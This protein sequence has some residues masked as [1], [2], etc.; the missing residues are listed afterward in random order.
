MLQPVGLSVTTSVF[1]ST[2]SSLPPQPSKLGPLS[3]ASEPRGLTT[4]LRAT[5]TLGGSM[6]LVRGKAASRR[7]ATPQPTCSQP[8][9][10]RREKSLSPAQAE[11]R[12]GGQHQRISP[13]VLCQTHVCH[14]PHTLLLLHFQ[15]SFEPEDAW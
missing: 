6:I 15:M 12:W 2:P 5:H 9:G 4:A 13:P 11:S 10:T 3:L 14:S 8:A 7:E 1:P